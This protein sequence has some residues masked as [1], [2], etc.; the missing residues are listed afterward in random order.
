MKVWR[1]RNIE[2]GIEIVEGKDKIIKIKREERNKE[3]KR[4]EDKESKEN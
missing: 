2:I 4:D 3:K 1:L